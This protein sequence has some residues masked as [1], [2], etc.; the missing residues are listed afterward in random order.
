MDLWINVLTF[1]VFWY[2]CSEWITWHVLTTASSFLSHLKQESMTIFPPL[3]NHQNP[4]Q[5]LPHLQSVMSSL[6]SL[7][8]LYDV[9]HVHMLQ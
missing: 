4:V 6:F 7:F 2:H 9:I 3:Q 5:T 1:L 8:L